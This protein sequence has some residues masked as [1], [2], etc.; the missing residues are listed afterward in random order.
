MPTITWDLA[1][2]IART[3]QGE[4]P[5]ATRP[6]ATRAVSSLRIAAT[7]GGELAARFSRLPG[8]PASQVEVVDRATWSGRSAD[9]VEEVLG[10]LGSTAPR[11]RLV[12]HLHGA[13]YGLAGGVALGLVSRGLLGQ[14]D[15]FSRRQVL[16]LL[17]PNLVQLARRL[18]GEDEDFYLWVCVH[19]QTHAL[20]FTGVEWLRD[21]TMG[22]LERTAGDE[23]GIVD[24]VR[25]L[26]RG[27]GFSTMSADGRSHMAGLMAVMTLVEGHADFIAD[28]VGRRHIPHSRSFRRHFA[29]RQRGSSRWAKLVPA[30]DKN[31]QYRIGL[32]FCTAVSRRKRIQGL[33]KV[34]QDPDALPSLEELQQPNLWMERVHGKA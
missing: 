12:R 6:E 1:L 14:F 34:F 19:E 31:A 21:H 18:P 4:L 29:K 33:N 13:G 2:P 8:Q 24:V 7:R 32:E 3:L 30:V 11:S 17:A 16:Y 9:M 15:A 22:L 20:Q 26:V 25:N 27:G 5:D 10:S 23:A 28:R